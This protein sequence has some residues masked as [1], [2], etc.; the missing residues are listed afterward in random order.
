MIIL[1]ISV[2]LPFNNSYL[3]VP[4]IWDCKYGERETGDP[5]GKRVMMEY[6]GVYGDFVNEYHYRRVNRERDL[7]CSV[8][9][10]AM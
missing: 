1:L 6:D 2:F 5:A 4:Y 8:I 7:Y 3:Y 9:D 10:C